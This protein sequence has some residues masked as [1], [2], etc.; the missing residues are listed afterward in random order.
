M[1]A[2]NVTNRCLDLEPVVA[3]L[4]QELS[5]VGRIREEFPADLAEEDKKQ[6]KAPSRHQERPSTGVR[7]QEAN[8]IRGCP[9]TAMNPLGK[10]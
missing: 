10:P 7:M 5:L 3:G 8:D 1:L 6:G 9:P 2:V 4:A